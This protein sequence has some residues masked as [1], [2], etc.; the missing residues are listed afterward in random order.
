M[1]TAGNDAYTQ[2]HMSS[3]FKEGMSFSGYERDFLALS[4]QGE[5]FEDVSGVSGVDSIGDGRGAVF[6]DFDNDGDLDIFLVSLQRD[7]HEL[8]RNNIGNQQGFLRVELL[9]TRSGPDAFGAVVRVGT[10]AG[11]VTK[12]KSGGS[13]FLAQHDPRLLFGLG[14]SARATWLEVTWPSGA[15]QRIEGGAGSDLLAA[16]SSLRIVEEGGVERLTER[17]FSLVDPLDSAQRL[18]ATLEFAPG[19]LFPDLA[20]KPRH[21]I[22]G[23]EQLAGAAADSLHEL[24]RPGRRL[25]VNLWATYCIPCRREMPEL[26]ALA[27]RFAANGIDLVGL[28][29]DT[30]SLDKVVPFLRDM[31][32]DYPI[33]VTHDERVSGLYVGGN[34]A[35][36]LSV[37]LDSDGRVLQVIGG[38]SA[39]TEASFDR[40]AD[41]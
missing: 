2:Q 24:L 35:I 20:L 32:A 11:V 29:I 16:G 7:A 6:A 12:I 25:L 14:A 3:I 26:Q 38:W 34:V 36:P 27:P 31:G 9:G 15:A 1:E 39:A 17:R 28:S 23:G 21:Q 22:P 19:A 37:L 40:L 33:H 5:R 10:D 13:G 41:R 4:H 8:F 30:A 18:L